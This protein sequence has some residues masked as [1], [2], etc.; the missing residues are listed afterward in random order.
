MAIDRAHHLKLSAS[1]LACQLE[2]ALG[3]GAPVEPFPFDGVWNEFDRKNLHRRLDEAIERRNA[4]LLEAAATK[5]EVEK[6][7]TITS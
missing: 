3:V 5:E 2:G 6:W 7:T 1:D 4:W